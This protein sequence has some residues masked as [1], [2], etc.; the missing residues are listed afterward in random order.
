VSRVESD[1]RQLQMFIGEW[2]SIAPLY[3]G[4]FYPLTPYSTEPTSW[5][6]WQ[7]DSPP[8][9]PSDPA[10]HQGVIQAF[11]RPESAF[12]TARFHLRGLKASASYAIRDLDTGKESRYM[13]KELT[14]IGLEVSIRNRP[15]V[16]IIAYRRVE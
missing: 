9:Y 5:I 11:R 3:Y 8:K 14:E 10:E 1:S 16:A 13:G 4:D 15:G 6:A 12:E 2:R 7:F